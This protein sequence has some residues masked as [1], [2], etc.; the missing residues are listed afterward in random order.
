MIMQGGHSRCILAR[1]VDLNHRLRCCSDWTACAGL[2]MHFCH[3]M[4]VLETQGLT[5]SA[6]ETKENAWA[7]ADTLIAL[8]HKEN[9]D[10]AAANPNRVL[11]F[12][13]IDQFWFS[14]AKGR[15][16]DS[17]CS[18]FVSGT[19]SCSVKS[20]HCCC[21]CI[22]QVYCRHE[23]Q[24][25]TLEGSSKVCMTSAVMADCPTVWHQPLC[26]DAGIVF[27]HVSSLLVSA[28]LSKGK[29]HAVAQTLTKTIAAESKKGEITDFEGMSTQCEPDSSKVKSEETEESEDLKVMMVDLRL[30]CVHDA[31]QCIAGQGNHTELHTT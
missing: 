25:V 5:L 13:Q 9:P 16:W 28:L 4:Q 31:H 8:C 21:C 11:G 14:C 27:G 12:D 6:F 18:C 19:S 1:L 30:A 29:E 2:C 22:D 7:A 24:L 23:D 26:Q 10:E 3:R 20:M 17:L 15:H